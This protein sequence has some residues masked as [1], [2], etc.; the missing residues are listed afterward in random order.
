MDA[1][2]ALQHLR[3]AL[4]GKN[5]AELAAEIGVSEATVSRWKAAQ[6]PPQKGLSKLVGW[7]E[8]RAASARLAGKISIGLSATGRLDPPK[9]TASTDESNVT[10]EMGTTATGTLS[11]PRQSLGYW[12][13][14]L[15][16]AGSVL[17]DAA[18]RHGRI[19]AEMAQA[20]STPTATREGMDAVG[21]AYLAGRAQGDTAPPKKAAQ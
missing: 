4:A 1:Q 16:E 9:P 14:R 8:K 17:E 21:S 12:L 11:D 18:A 2:T 15:E 7:A 20:L 10:L 3:E 13:G 19:R 5:Q 6:S